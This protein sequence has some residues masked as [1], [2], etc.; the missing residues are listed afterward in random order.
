[1]IETIQDTLSELNTFELIL[2]VLFG[3]LFILRLVY[4]FVFTGRILFRK[5][6]MDIEK[7]DSP[8]SLLLTVR[9]EEFNLKNNLP[10]ILK[11]ENATFEV[12]AVDDFSADNSL[13]VLGSLKE[14][15][16]K[17]ILSSLNQE[18]WF[19]NKLA[20][21]I[22][23]KAAKNEWVMVIP[24]SGFDFDINWLSKI[25]ET[26]E[27]NHVVINYSNI[28]NTG[29]FYN[30]LFR[31]ES[32]LQQVKSYGFVLNRLP[33]VY[34]EENVAFKKDKYFEMG[35]FGQKISE[36]FANLELLIN[37]FIKKKSTEI[38]FIKETVIC[39]SEFVKKADYFELLKKSFRI[40]KHLLITKRF[41]LFLEEFTHL[42]FLPAIIFVIVLLPELWFIIVILL[43]L[44]II[45]RLFIIKT[46]L[47]RLNERKIFLSSFAYD[48]LMPYF[49]LFYRWH[50][51]QRS[52]KQTWR[53]KI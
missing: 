42:L 2:L 29:E 17:L 27:E 51:N 13:S 52:R 45:A 7:N 35:G 40:E 22:A 6:K 21:N 23:L 4:Q 50:F 28:K 32:F 38:C 33:F 9:N 26:F 12:V 41:V 49:K 43:G 47:N 14:K 3:V 25:S 30:H 24:A 46:I 34:S 39:K 5:D 1:M 53:S 8:I 11:I 48:L 31:I 20:Q 37:S 15:S 36:P 18:T 16:I 10:E 44:I 19:S